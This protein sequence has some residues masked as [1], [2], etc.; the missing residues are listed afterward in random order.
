[1]NNTGSFDPQQPGVSDALSGLIDHDGGVA[2]TVT[3]LRRNAQAP[4]LKAKS[5]FALE[6]F[7]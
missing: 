4:R 7:T 1:M 6:R 3:H 5:S 2:W